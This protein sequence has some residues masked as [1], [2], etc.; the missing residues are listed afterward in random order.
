MP[1]RTG[2]GARRGS[3]PRRPIAGAL[4]GALLATLVGCLTP[5]V[6]IEAP[7]VDLET[8]LP[9]FPEGTETVAVTTYDGA[10]LRGLFV[11]AGEGAPVV[12]HLLESAGSVGSLMPSKSEIAHDSA[13][14]GFASLLI[15]YRGVGISP[16]E[17]SP[18]HHP[19]LPA[20]VLRAACGAQAWL[21]CMV[22][23]VPHTLACRSTTLDWTVPHFQA[24]EPCAHPWRRV[25]GFY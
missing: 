17:R 12:L 3:R 19:R 18:G 15:D 14:L 6:M 21:S 8:A 24:W 9:R 22:W 1:Q 20:C 2:D 11:P 4:G 13:N 16:G 25:W 10:E 5:P 7:F 23:L